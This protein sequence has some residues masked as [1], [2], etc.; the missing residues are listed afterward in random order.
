M[1][2]QVEKPAEKPQTTAEGVAFEGLLSGEAMAHLKALE[3]EYGQWVAIKPIPMGSALAFVPGQQVP[4]YH[5]TTYEL[6]KQG[7]V[8]RAG[9]KEA[10]RAQGM[11]D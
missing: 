9:S 7:L 5:V 3:D 1:P 8:A 4:V 11:E 2:A 10:R 6:E